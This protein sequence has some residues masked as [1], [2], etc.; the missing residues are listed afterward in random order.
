MVCTTSSPS[1][2]FF[3]TGD[4][5]VSRLPSSWQKRICSTCQYLVPA[6]VEAVDD[7]VALEHVSAGISEHAVIKCE[8]FFDS[9]HETG[10]SFSFSMKDKH[11]HAAIRQVMEVARWIGT[12]PI[13]SFA[14]A[15]IFH[16]P[17]EHSPAP[18]K[19][20]RIGCSH[21]SHS[22][23]AVIDPTRLMYHSPLYYARNKVHS[24]PRLPP[25]YYSGMSAAGTSATCGV[26][27]R[28]IV[29]LF[30]LMV[31]SWRF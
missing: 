14:G 13:G 12:Q 20:R 6:H 11:H 15:G 29:V 8:F 7:L 9:R 2:G 22:S 3:D 23:A 5:S 31:A 17:G 1:N 16:R 24:R 19:N 18:P 26:A 25:S 4:V 10:R 30:S 27:R 28:T 21:W